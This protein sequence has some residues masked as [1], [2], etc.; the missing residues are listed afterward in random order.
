MADYLSIAA[1]IL[2]RH[3]GESIS[4]T[5]RELAI[6]SQKPYDSD[7]VTLNLEKISIRDSKY[8]DSDDYVAQRELVLHGEGN[9]SGKG[10]NSPLP[11]EAYE[12]PI[13]GEFEVQETGAGIDIQTAKAQYSIKY[14]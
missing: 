14:Q 5:K 1:E 2:E 4:I 7:Y 8:T 13:V 3:R 10:R 11:Q 12:I 9:L 6:G